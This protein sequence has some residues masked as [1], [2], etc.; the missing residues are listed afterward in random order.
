MNRQE[1][2]Y[3]FTKY[4]NRKYTDYEWN[5]HGHK[6]YKNFETEISECEEHFNL[7]T[8]IRVAILLSGHIRKN[9]ILSG[10]LHFL[11]KFNYDVFIHTWDNLGYKGSE[12]N[13]NDNVDFESVTNEINNFLSV[14]D[15][16]IENNKDFINKIDLKK[17][18]F[19][20]SSPEAFIIS[21]LYSINKSY[22]LMEKY[23]LENDVKY[24]IVFKFRFDCSLDS[25]TL[26]KDII[27]D[28][29]NHNIIFTPNNKDSNHSHHDYGTSCWACDNMYYNHNLKNVHIFEHTNV[30]CDLFAYGSQNSM[31]SYCSLYNVYDKL[32]DSF[33][34]K[35]LKSYELNNKHINNIDGDYK[36]VGHDGHI[37]S[38]YYYYCSYPERLLQKHLNDYMLVE[39]RKIKLSLKR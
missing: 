20:F 37:D 10:V 23:S 34:E 38:L 28:V 15:Y 7:N 27:T 5:V 35:N 4:L 8:N 6:D 16:L 31:K 17:G 11:K 12:T 9:N 39:S 3:L 29:N 13:L 22:L 33:I 30:I 1:L 19:N 32:N 24:D 36:L 26:T 14:K 21:Q 2:E 18:Y 25:F